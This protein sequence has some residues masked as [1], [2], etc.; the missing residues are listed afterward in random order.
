MKNIFKIIKYFI[1]LGKMKTEHII[2]VLTILIFLMIL[3]QYIIGYI[4]YTK[5]SKMYT[6]DVKPM[7]DKA[8][9]AINVLDNVQ[10]A[11]RNLG[12]MQMSLNNISTQLAGIGKLGKLF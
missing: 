3:G 1:E 4:A 9:S 2:L 10:P 7:I 12:G 8:Q 5:V 6:S 11:L